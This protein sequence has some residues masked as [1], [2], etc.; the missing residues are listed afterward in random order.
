MTYMYDTCDYHDDYTTQEGVLWVYVYI[1]VDI[2]TYEYT[3]IGGNTC[4]FICVY[5][6]MY[7]HEKLLG[8]T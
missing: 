6:Y 8:I 4:M 3:C 7:P 1:H 5:I 2:Y